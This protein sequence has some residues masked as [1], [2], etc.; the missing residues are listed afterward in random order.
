VKGVIRD[1]RVRV[2]RTYNS[3]G[4]Y[5]SN[6][7]RHLDHALFVDSPYVKRQSATRHARHAACGMRHAAC[8]MRHAACEP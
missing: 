5:E 4:R 7:A 2:S 6:N 3:E 1:R 8:G